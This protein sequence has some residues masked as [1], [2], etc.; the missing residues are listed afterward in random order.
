MEVML[1]TIT[2]TILVG[3]SA[4]CSG[5]NVALLTLR[6]DDLRRKAKLGDKHA[7]TALAIRRKVHFY[8]AGILLA[9]VAF[10]SATSVVLNSLLSGFLA[11]VVSTLALVIFA[12]I[13]PQAFAIRHAKDA[14]AFFAPAIRIVS[15]IGYPITRPIEL[16]LDRMVGKSHTVLHTRHELSLL[17]ADHLNEPSELDENEVE[18]VQ[19]TLKLSETRVKD[20][21]TPISHVYH[22][23]NTTRVGQNK[24]E[25]MKNSHYSRIPIFNKNHTRGTHYI[26]MKDL[27][28]Y[29]FDEKTYEL[30]ELPRHRAKKVG[31]MTALDTLFQQFI[32]S[33][34]HMMFVEKDNKLVGIITIEDL[35]EAVIGHEIYDEK[36]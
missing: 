18:I 11:V 12:E 4:L 1:I 32:A 33:K 8:L 3:L 5:L 20:V 13:T 27:H 28:D 16:L 31:S 26:Y 25:E 7:K 14:V 6:V 34:K 36:D 2:A 15:Y 22:I 29:D 10:A 9:N 17:I 30:N 21:M 24:F 23:S 35:I 19:S